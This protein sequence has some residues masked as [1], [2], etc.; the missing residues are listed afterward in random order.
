MYYELIFGNGSQAIIYVFRSVPE[1]SR[2]PIRRVSAL[3]NILEFWPE[4]NR[5]FFSK[6]FGTR[7]SSARTA[8]Y[9]LPFT[10]LDP[11]PISRY[12]PFTCAGDALMGCRNSE[13][14]P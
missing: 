11:W 7:K 13:S 8:L 6:K 1:T 12:F 9:D 14:F 3:D 5:N 4:I 2:S 10:G